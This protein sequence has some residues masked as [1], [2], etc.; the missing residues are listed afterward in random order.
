MLGVTLNPKPLNRN[1]KYKAGAQ[2]NIHTDFLPTW[3][4]SSSGSY[5]SRILLPGDFNILN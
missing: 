2:E 1:P 4:S 5:E 3:G